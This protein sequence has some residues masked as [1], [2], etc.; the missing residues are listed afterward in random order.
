MVTRQPVTKTLTKEKKKSKM[1]LEILILTSVCSIAD[2][3]QT[4][5]N[6]YRE[7]LR[8]SHNQFQPLAQQVLLDGL[9]SRM[10]PQHKAPLGKQR[11]FQS[12][13]R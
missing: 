8:L 6:I 4:G 3:D 7:A 2:R 1:F 11:A 12:L 13:A 5:D 10:T 9:A